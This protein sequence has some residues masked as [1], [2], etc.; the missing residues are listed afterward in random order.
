M[1]F[2]T[3]FGLLAGVLVWRGHGRPASILGAMAALVGATALL[4]P[5]TALPFYRAWMG[6]GFFV[7]S[8]V[9]RAVLVLIFYGV[10]TPVSLLFR[11]AGRD[12]LRLKKGGDSYWAEHPRLDDRE[13]PKHL[14]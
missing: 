7:G 5:A 3:G 13:N 1:I 2:L 8:G 12:A 4:S 6:I 10:V 14:F 9:S 11:L